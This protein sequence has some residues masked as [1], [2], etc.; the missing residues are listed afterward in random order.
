MFK[1]LYVYIYSQ[2]NIFIVD[3]HLLDFRLPSH[4]EPNYLSFSPVMLSRSEHFEVVKVNLKLDPV[5]MGSVQCPPQCTT[6]V[7]TVRSQVAQT[8]TLSPLAW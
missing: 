5:D 7:H 3:T 6:Q 8:V 4:C 1:S 2:R